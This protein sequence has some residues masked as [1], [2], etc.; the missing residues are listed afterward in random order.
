MVRL[1]I[2]PVLAQ[3]IGSRGGAFWAQIDHI[4]GLSSQAAFC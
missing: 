1:L 4:F 2:A 3:N